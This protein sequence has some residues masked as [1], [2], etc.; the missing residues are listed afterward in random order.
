MNINIDICIGI[1]ICIIIGMDIGNDILFLCFEF[2]TE[3]FSPG[4]R[5]LSSFLHVHMSSK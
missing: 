2:E 1:G 5:S 4:K 3:Q